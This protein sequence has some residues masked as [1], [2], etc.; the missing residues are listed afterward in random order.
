MKAVVHDTYGPPE[1]LRITEIARPVPKDDE[2][3]VKVHASSVTRTD[4]GFRNSEYFFTRVFTGLRRPKRK[5]PGL[6]LAGVVD[7]VG[8]AVTEFQIGDEVFGIRGGANAEYVCVRES[9]PRS[10]AGEHDL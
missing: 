3:L 4:T 5:I 9:G 7:A 2:L 10:Q 8:A 1:V 6:E